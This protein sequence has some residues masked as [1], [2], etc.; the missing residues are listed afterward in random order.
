MQSISVWAGHEHD[1][2]AKISNI[3]E[4]CGIWHKASFHRLQIGT[5]SGWL[6]TEVRE[7]GTVEHVHRHAPL[8]IIYESHAAHL[9]R[10][11]I[12]Y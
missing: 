11:W 8:T 12:I 5:T 2:P 7:I 10:L 4:R 3:S 6:V 9:L 1:I